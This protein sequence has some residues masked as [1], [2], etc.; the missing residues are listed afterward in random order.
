[1]S[2]DINVYRKRKI[3]YDD[4]VTFIEDEEHIYDCNITHNLI[5]MAEE[6]DIYDAVWRP[7]RLHPAFHKFDNRD[8]EFEFESSTVIKAKDIS[9]VIENGLD[10]MKKR[11]EHYKQFNSKN[12]WGIYKHFV[13]FLEKYL[14][15]LK[16]YPNAIIK[17]SR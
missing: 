8:D 13:P 7:Y 10:D 15:V 14:E 16:R 2:L 3:S 12:G 1:M 5:E 9:D 17:C 11:P 4:G 6:A